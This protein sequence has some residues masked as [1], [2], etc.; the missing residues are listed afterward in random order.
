[1][2]GIPE[3]AAV[4]NAKTE[5]LSGEGIEEVLSRVLRLL[6]S[7]SDAKSAPAVERPSEAKEEKPPAPADDEESSS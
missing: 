1:M 5:A 4:V 2:K 6:T 7:R 3:L